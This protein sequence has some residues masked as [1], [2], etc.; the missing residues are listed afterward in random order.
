MT[1]PMSTNAQ[2][3]IQYPERFTTPMT[4]SCE[5]TL[6]PAR[7]HTATS[8]MKTATAMRLLVTQVVDVRARE[9]P[10]RGE[11]RAERVQAPQDNWDGPHG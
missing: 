1:A 11:H 9:Y 3:T 8:T 4:F 2:G 6:D 10:S 7:H 5:P